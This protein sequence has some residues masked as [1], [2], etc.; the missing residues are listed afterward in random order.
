MA[1]AT[2]GH[3]YLKLYRQERAEGELF[4]AYTAIGDLSVV[5]CPKFAKYVQILKTPWLPSACWR[6]GADAAAVE[7]TGGWGGAGG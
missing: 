1:F 4:G 7:E 6:E 2:R 3:R 5:K